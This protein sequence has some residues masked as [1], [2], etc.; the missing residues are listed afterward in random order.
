MSDI[1]N[2]QSLI[3]TEIEQSVFIKNPINL[4]EPIEYTMSMG[5]KRIR[6]LLCLL[7]V[8]L[9]NGDT[10][11]AVKPAIGLEIFHNFTLLHDDIMDNAEV[12]RN[13]PTVHKKWNNNVG[14]LSGDAML[15]NA[16]QYISKCN[17]SNLK[18]VLQLFNDVAIGVCE[19][20][21]YD[22]DFENRLDVTIEEY[23]EM[24]RLK[25]AILLAGSLKLGAL[26]A[27]ASSTE[28]E[29]I[30]QFGINIGLAFQLQDD[31][32][33]TFGN[34]DTFGKKI[35]GDILCNKK[36]YLLITALNNSSKEDTDELKYWINAENFND[37]EKITNVKSIYIKNAVDK[38]SHHLMDKYFNLAMENLI[39]ING[40]EET[41]KELMNFATKLM[42]RNN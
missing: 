28:A 2:L 1:Q 25:T 6:P 29:L 11:E 22:M 3:T 37:Q 5:G 40:N 12:R 27:N 7:A 15:I 19:G 8:Q 35:G 13:K 16:Y 34:Q 10:Q 41:K 30:Y 23:L 38:K 14:I 39:Q 9:F 24:I 20:Q 18:E 31:Y 33:D 21:Q 32:L 4:Y 42:Q 26:L 36:T 17:T